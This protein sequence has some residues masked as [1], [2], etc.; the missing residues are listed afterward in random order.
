MCSINDRLNRN[1]N[2][3]DKV[4]KKVLI[5]LPLSGA[6]HS[7]NWDVDRKKWVNCRFTICMSVKKHW[8]V[9]MMMMMMIEYN[10]NK[11]WQT[12]INDMFKL[13][14]IILHTNIHSRLL[15]KTQKWMSKWVNEW[16]RTSAERRM[17]PKDEWSL[18]IFRGPK[19]QKEDT[20]NQL[21][22]I[23]LTN[24]IFFRLHTLAYCFHS[25]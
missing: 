1:M 9:W 7:E 2:E 16:N 14:F 17:K 12:K 22:R 25:N 4:L 24:P 6:V 11:H 20:K 5:C 8:C 18:A 10:K 13:C 3:R 21:K 19:R 15:I 23:F